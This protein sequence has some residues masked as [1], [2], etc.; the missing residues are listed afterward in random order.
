M[1]NEEII[2]RTNADSALSSRIDTLN[3]DLNT[4]SV[5]RKAAPPPVFLT[6]ICPQHIAGRN[7]NMN[8]NQNLII[9]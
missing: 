8:T 2:D 1:I 5:E 4:E 7:I 9:I 6:I 3:I